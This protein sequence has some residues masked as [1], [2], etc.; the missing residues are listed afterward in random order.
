MP[1]RQ[2]NISLNPDHALCSRIDSPQKNQAQM[3]EYLPNPVGKMQSEIQLA[4]FHYI[5]CMKTRP[6]NADC[7]LSLE[8]VEY[9]FE[10]I[11]EQKNDTLHAEF[12]RWASS[13]V[14]R[15]LIESF[16]IFLMEL[17][18]EALKIKPSRRYSTTL[19][20]FERMGIEDQLDVI[21]TDFQ[22]DP[23]WAVRLAGYNKARNSLAHRQGIVGARDV[24][25]GNELVIRWLVAKFELIEGQ[26]QSVVINSPMKGLVQAQHIE[27]APAR[28]EINDK[29]KRIPVGSAIH[30]SPADI[31]EVC[32]TLQ[33]ATAAYGLI[34]EPDVKPQR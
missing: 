6:T 29:E 23:R 11:S 18:R 14:L 22:I 8:N 34:L 2:N 25:D 30:F 5:V 32:Q 9:S 15:D 28:V 10:N 12:Q 20:K 27:G 1:E 21:S 26:A 7:K 33:L 3:S 31:L 24:T 19:E 13:C 4:G 16:S 17:Y